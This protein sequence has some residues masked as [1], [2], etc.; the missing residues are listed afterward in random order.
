M[1]AIQRLVRTW[2]ASGRQEEIQG[3]VAG[4]FYIYFCSKSCLNFV[5]PFLLEALRF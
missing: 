4:R 5:Q 2:V 3:T 1:E